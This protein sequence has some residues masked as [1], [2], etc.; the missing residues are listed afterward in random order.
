MTTATAMLDKYLAA[1]EAIL[2]GKEVTLEN[3]RKLRL[4]D[5]PA[6]QDG[7]REWERRVAAEQR[8]SSGI[9]TLGGKRISLGRPR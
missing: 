2:A 8:Q 5:L 9:P 3:G 1:E 4:E 7:R 6:I